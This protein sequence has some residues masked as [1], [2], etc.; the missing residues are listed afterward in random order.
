M[1]V[2]NLIKA[3]E[4]AHKHRNNFE[5]SNKAPDVCPSLGVRSALGWKIVIEHVFEEWH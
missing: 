3:V 5:C 2:C 1:A 4:N